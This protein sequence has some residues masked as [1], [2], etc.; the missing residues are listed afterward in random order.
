MSGNRTLTAAGT[1]CLAMLLLGFFD[2]FV[3][4]IARDLG[5]WQFHL[6]RAIMAVGI[7][8]LLSWVGRARLNPIRRWAVTIRG[9]FAA[10]AMLIY[11]GSLAF[12]PIGQVAAGLFTAPL[13]V[14]L[15]GALFLGEPVGLTRISAAVIGFAGV[16]IVLDPFAN[17][18]D[19]V[20]LVPMTAGFFYAI[21]GIA[22][23]QWCEGESALSMLLYFFLAL[24]L[25]G[26]IGSVVMTLWVHE[27]P[28][29]AEG[30]ILRGVVWPT[31]IGWG[32]TVMQA[33]GSLVAVGLIFKGYQ[34]GDA[35]QVAI[36]EYLL[37][38]FAAGWGLVLFG[39]PVPARAIF[40]MVLIIA[41]GAII[42]LRSRAT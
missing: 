27:V 3:V 33:V 13:W 5:L 42:S 9:G 28:A 16:L 37:L 22:T 30:F 36:Y 18:L 8:V 39:D 6:M 38:P 41:S 17:G 12:L 20:A 19:P 15:I 32:L 10:L 34:M 26:L 23:R 2:N 1:I 35:A 14:L 31:P 40:G 29:G 11:F 4:L 7:L 24:G 25:F 21:G